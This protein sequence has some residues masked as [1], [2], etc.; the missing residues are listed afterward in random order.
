M[1]A[2]NPLEK[3]GYRLLQ[4]FRIQDLCRQEVRARVRH[5]TQEQLDGA[6]V[7]DLP[8]TRLEMGFGPFS[9]LWR[10]NNAQPRRPPPLCSNMSVL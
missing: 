9:F 8:S 10:R 6:C 2:E 3:Q 1:G 7:G 4:L 5:S